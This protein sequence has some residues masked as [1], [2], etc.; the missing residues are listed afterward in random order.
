MIAGQIRSEQERA[1]QCTRGGMHKRSKHYFCA[2]KDG[3]VFAACFVYGFAGSIYF[4]FYRAALA[5]ADAAGHSS[6]QAYLAIYVLFVRDS[7]HCRQH[8]FRPARADE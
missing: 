1:L 4:A 2:V 3:A 7:G 5:Q 8:G 6:F